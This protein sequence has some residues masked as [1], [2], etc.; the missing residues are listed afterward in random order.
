MAGFREFVTGEVLT[1]ANVDDFLA[2][3]A[4]MKFADAAARDAALGTA[5][6]GGNALRE[7]MVAYLDDEDAPSFYDGSAW[8]PISV[9]IAGIGSN[10]V[11]VTKT[12]TFT[13]SSN[14]FV[15]I[16]GLSATI[17][18]S[19]ATSKIL[20]VAMLT[21]SQDIG[22]NSA[23]LQLVR[24]STAIAIGDAEGVRSR[25]TTTFAVYETFSLAST[26]IV[27]LDSPATT[28]ATTYK[29]QGRTTATGSF[30]VNRQETDDSNS[31]RPRSI[32]SLLV[33]EVAA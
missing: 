20:V 32:S 11:S 26:N 28:S 7:G 30:F 3:Q 31:A 4:V 5:V 10:V 33:A 13:S 21:G 12:D 15:D 23:F 24:D 9:P 17:T 2:K 27:Y 25:V 22:T 18:P 16:T 19:S 6:A 29:I 14:T 8:G 1:A